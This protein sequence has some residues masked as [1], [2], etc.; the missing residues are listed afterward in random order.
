M[1]LCQTPR[2]QWFKAFGE[3]PGALQNVHSPRHGILMTTGRPSGRR[4]CAVKQRLQPAWSSLC[5]VLK[6]NRSV[7]S[8]SAQT[9]QLLPGLH[10][11][12]VHTWQRTCMGTWEKRT[13]Y[14]SLRLISR[15]SSNYRIQ[16]SRWWRSYQCT[17]W[18]T[19]KAHWEVAQGR[20]VW[21]TVMERRQ[22]SGV[23][24]GRQPRCHQGFVLRETWPS[25]R[26]WCI[27]SHQHCLL[28]DTHTLQS[29]LR[30]NT[31]GQVY[32]SLYIHIFVFVCI[33]LPSNWQFFSAQQ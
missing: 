10:R 3:L 26:Q 27:D 5:D 33:C 18:H 13:A 9:V 16:I 31:G 8:Q 15:S 14:I 25:L 29:S 28:L 17:H 32:E 23:S 12:T 20:W 6:K 4:R 24:Q 22:S 1:N 21:E 30:Q 11:H 2:A 19:Y 7:P